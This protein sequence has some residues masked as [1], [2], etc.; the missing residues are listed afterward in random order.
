MMR[1][2]SGKR[3]MQIACCLRAMLQGHRVGVVAHDVS[4]VVAVRERCAALGIDETLIYLLKPPSGKW[5][6][7]AP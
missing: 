3:E 2:Q 6:T 4:L 1:R 7:V 5:L